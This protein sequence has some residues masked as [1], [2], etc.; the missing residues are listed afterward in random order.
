MT[1]W[2]DPRDD[3]NPFPTSHDADRLLGEPRPEDL[4][5]EAAPLATLFSSMRKQVATQDPAAEIS[6]IAAL[7]AGIRDQ[8]IDSAAVVISQFWAAPVG[9]GRRARVRRRAGNRHRGRGRERVTPGSGA[10]RGLERA[11]SRQHLGTESG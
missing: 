8:E 6:A 1:S 9:A 2:D 5:G 3:M 11:L 7:A 10:T 4:H